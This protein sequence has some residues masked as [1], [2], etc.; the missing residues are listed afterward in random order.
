MTTIRPSSRI[1]KAAASTQA[2]PE[3]PHELPVDRA[4][5]MPCSTGSARAKQVTLLDEFLAAVDWRGAF[6]VGRWLSRSMSKT[7]PG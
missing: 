3:T 6:S 4:R 5:S 2:L 1:R 7:S